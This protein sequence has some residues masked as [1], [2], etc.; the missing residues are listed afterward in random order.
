MAKTKETIKLENLLFA[1]N[2]FNGFFCIFEC[3]I[4]FGGGGRVDCIS[5]DTRNCIRCFEIKVTKSDFH[6]KHGHNF[7]GNLNYYVMPYSLYKQVKD[8]IP[9]EIGVLCP[10]NSKFEQSTDLY[11][12][13]KAKK[14]ECMQSVED[15]KLYIIRSL[16]RE[17]EKSIYSENKNILAAYEKDKRRLIRERD[18]Y[19]KLLSTL[20]ANIRS[21]LGFNYGKFR[22]WLQTNKKSI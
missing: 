22:S 14:L 9:K 20:N 17:Y 4:G 21:Y 6:S 8:E 13:K 16:F 19:Y 1:Y 3:T 15:I 2:R 10:N 18:N 11:I 5:I 7:V 12:E